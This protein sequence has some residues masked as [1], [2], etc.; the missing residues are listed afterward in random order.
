MDRGHFLIFWGQLISICGTW[1]Q[2]VAQSC[3]VRQLTDPDLA[4][5][6]LARIRSATGTLVPGLPGALGTTMKI[7][8]ITWDRAEPED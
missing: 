5:R 6:Q 2:T 8:K 1:M 3:L 7:K 4:L